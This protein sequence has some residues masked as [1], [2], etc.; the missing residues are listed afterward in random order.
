LYFALSFLFL[1]FA[2]C[3]NSVI[4][5]EYKQK[6]KIM[7]KENFNYHKIF[8]LSL[9]SFVLGFVDAFWTYTLST[10]FSEISKTN[11]VGIFYLVAFIG[12]LVSLFF[13]QPVIGRI[14]RSRLLYFSLGLSILFV[15]FLTQLSPS[16][17]S[18]F[19]VL[20]FIVSNNIV[21]VALDVLIEGFSSDKMAGRIR[22][23]HLTITNSGVLIAPFLAS[24]VLDNFHFEGIFF[25]LGIGYMVVFLI[26]LLAFRNDNVT[27]H[28]RL[29]PWHAIQRMIHEKNILYIYIISFALDLFYA[30]MIIYTSL[31]LINMGF[32]WDKI[33]IIFTIML[34]PFVLLQYPLGVIADKHLGE[35][36]LLIVS[37]M[38]IIFSTASIPFIHSYSLWVWGTV[39]FMTRVGAAGIEVLRDAY[40]YKQIDG[41]N[42]DLIAFFRTSRPVATIIGTIIA[43][44]VLIFWS[45][46]SIFFVVVIVMICALVATIL[47]ED[48]RGE[49]ELYQ[50]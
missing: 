43:S 9:V 37:I 27:F 1:I 17:F 22:G 28:E 36:E 39:L 13:I 26:S 19:I 10:Y 16:W 34:V 8:L 49:N 14:G 3:I 30:L 45:L 21:W 32:S 2:F 46:K 18:I 44:L 48:T 41:D 25:V 15:T 11:N 50:L 33:G 20:L 42:P 6:E 4:I 12:V 47:L 7:H 31:Y 40:F 38:I 23:L 29:K 35:K 5:K 24:K